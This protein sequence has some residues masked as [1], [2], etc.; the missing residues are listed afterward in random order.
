MR[1]LLS[2]PL[3]ALL[4]V[5]VVG[6]AQTR[7]ITVTT[8]PQDA[9]IKVDGIDRGKGQV[10]EEFIFQNKN[11]THVVTVSRLGYKEQSIPVK[12]DHKGDTLNVDLKPLTAK[13]TINVAPV[14]AKISIDGESVGAET[15]TVT[16]EL[17]FTVDAKNQWTTHTVAAERDGFERVERVI[18]WQDKEPV[19][20]L[21]LE[22]QKKNLNVTTN[23]PGAQ[24]YLD[25]ES[26]GNSPVAVTAR[27]FPIDLVTNEAVPQK[28]RV[29]RPGYDPVEMPISWDAGKNDYH[30]DLTAKTK[31]VKFI[32]DPPGAAVTIDGK[33]VEK[34]KSGVPTATLQFPP[35]DEKGNLKTYKVAISKKT[36]DSEW[37]PQAMTLAWDSGRAD[38]P[39]KLKEILTRPVTLL[40]PELQ[41]A[42]DGWEINPTVTTTIAM[43]DVSEG[44][45]KEPPLQITKLPRGTQIDTL[46]V[47]PDGSRLLF[48]VIYGTT[49]PTFRSQMIAIR[50][51]GSGGA[52]YLSDG[53]SLEITPSFTP[54]GDQIVFSSNRAG[55]RLSVWSMSA[56]GAPGITQLTTG[57]TNDLWATIDSDPKKRLFYQAN[58]DTRPDPRLYM[59]A[60]GTTTRTDLT[61]MSGAQPR[62][63]PK[64]DSIIFTAVNDKTGKRDLYMMPDRGGVPR[65]LTNTPDIDEFDPAWNK[66][67]TRIAFVSEA[68]VDEE[69]RQNYDIW[70]LDMAR[71]ERPVQIT[72]N[73]SHDDHP[74]WDPT[75]SA[76]YFRSNRGGEWAIWKI[77]S[78]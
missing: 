57:D 49:R 71:T 54:D 78:R 45:K 23:P 30:V 31:T 63:S 11:E 27:P 50:T 39:I 29:V 24:V 64:A 18:T 16:R 67:A 2:F 8:K 76:L 3:S 19:Y 6:C 7:Q 37:E 62:V 17:P 47:S 56:T 10:T 73:G 21:R 43:K 15:D 35:V 61:Q 20:N 51:D 46:A 68:G 1:R 22:P 55:R 44:A 33:P 75:G 4:L 72:T 48:T 74:A 34:D 12:G 40:T 5:S 26:L 41:R 38:Y 65:N 59:T 60:L 28:L 13:V 66:D 9:F 25:G 69:R 53:K 77:S 42:D 14:P 58:V 32:T 52:D 36:V 70:V